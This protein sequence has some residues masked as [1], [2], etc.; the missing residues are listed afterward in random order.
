MGQG[1]R[2]EKQV[3]AAEWRQSWQRLKW[4]IPAFLA[5]FPFNQICGYAVARGAAPS[6]FYLM[7]VLYCFMA[8]VAMFLLFRSEIR[9][10]HAAAGAHHLARARARE[11]AILLRLS[12]LLITGGIFLP[13]LRDIRLLEPEA[14]QILHYTRILLDAGFMFVMLI[15][16]IDLCSGI[17]FEADSDSVED[18]DRIAAQRIHAVRVGYVTIVLG[19]SALYLTSLYRPQWCELLL[20][21]LIAA[22]LVY[23][24]I[25]FVL[26]DGH[27]TLQGSH[28]PLRS[29]YVIALLGLAGLHTA[30]Q[31]QTIPCQKLLLLLIAVTLIFQGVFTLHRQ[32]RA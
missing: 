12:L 15:T 16:M 1:G 13:L 31:F 29:G 25:V 32:L 11:H 4:A 27:T 28:R 8:M 19:M 3:A 14:M 17:F 10:R 24:I 2:P 5:I 7:P 18:D 21:S 6:W 9:A 26:H 20:P 22:A 23:P 30:S